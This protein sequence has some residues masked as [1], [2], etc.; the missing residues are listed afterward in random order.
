MFVSKIFMHTGN[1]SSDNQLP[2]VIQRY[3]EMLKTDSVY[4]F[5]SDEYVFI[6]QYY[7]DNGQFSK[8]E[9]AL[10]MGLEQ[11][12]DN[13]PLQIVHSEIL[14]LK[15]KNEQALQIL[16][17]ARLIEPENPELLY[18]LASVFSKTG[19]H[20]EA[21][22]ILKSIPGSDD[23][24]YADIT[25]M[26]GNEYLILEQYSEAAEFFI[27][28]LEIDPEDSSALHNLVFCYEMT[29]EYERCEAFLQDFIDH[30]P[31]NKIAWYQLG[32]QYFHMQKYDKALQAFDYAV[33]IDEFF[34]GAY[35]EIA[36]I[37][38]FKQ[39]CH[40]ALEYFLI[41]EQISEPS[42]QL[43]LQ[44]ASCYDQL[45]NADKE[46]DYLIKAH[47][48]DPTDEKPLLSLSNIYAKSGESR[49]H[50]QILDKLLN[51]DENNPDY[52]KKYADANYKIK[53]YPEAIIAYKK[54]LS[55]NKHALEIYMH[56]ADSHLKLKQYN[57][58]INILG[59]A[60]V[61]YHNRAEIYY[62]MAGLQFTVNNTPY[63][64][65]YFYRAL[66]V[67]FGLISLFKEMFPQYYHSKVIQKA[68]QLHG[69]TV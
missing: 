17:S 30:N 44:I 39:L 24:S 20:Q 4:F 61:F 35:I 65:A 40:K 64:L 45:G 23:I 68:I 69:K 48:E 58:A 42:L 7:L 6:S 41:T 51:L 57:E 34:A 5:D 18:Q 49:K 3:E 14:I 19:N 31:Y 2:E 55:F 22:H 8:A 21:I 46:I 36:K 63:G 38:K 37:Y 10:N 59:K 47:H 52:W 60:E 56:L 54:Y 53:F 13:I 67:N 62:R 15:D 25:S 12:P 32:R 26:L 11:Y 16:E 28:T 9:N 27:D 29:E 43:Y 66:K 1:N 33:L 50:I